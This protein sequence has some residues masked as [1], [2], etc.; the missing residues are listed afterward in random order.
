MDEPTKQLSE[1]MQKLA[2]TLVTLCGEVDDLIAAGE[3]T[4]GALILGAAGQMLAD[5]ASQVVMVQ[6]QGKVQELLGQ[7][8]PAVRQGD[9]S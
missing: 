6:V 8:V 2:D 1:P 5:R 3:R 7:S 9:G 4:K